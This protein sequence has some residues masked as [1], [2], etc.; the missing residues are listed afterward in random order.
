MDQQHPP[1]D[2]QHQNKDFFSLFEVSGDNI[3]RGNENH[4]Q[5][6]YHSPMATTPQ[7]A[8]NGA[9]QL[10]PNLPI[11]FDF[12]NNIMGMQGQQQSTSTQPP[13]QFNPQ[14]VIEQKLKLNQLQQ[15]QLQNQ[16]LQQQASQ[17]VL[18]LELLSG[19]GGMP[20]MEG[21][22]ERQ[23][24][25]SNYLGLPTPMSSTELQ[26]QQSSSNEYVSPMALNYID[27]QF[28]QEPQSQLPPPD[29]MAHHHM[30]HAAH[31]THSA[32]ANL[33]FNTNPPVPLPSP[34]QDM[35]FDLSPITSPWIEAYHPHERARHNAIT[36]A[37]RRPPR[38]S[39]RGP[40][41][42][43]LLPRSALRSPRR[44]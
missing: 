40:H 44:R 13:A 7:P 27:N 34:G 24:G 28:R 42:R 22:A 9:N 1:Q 37:P 31:A 5:G 8:M 26:P 18:N 10:L 29:M 17:L 43:A 20:A 3:Q 4:Q 36:S 32:P 35:E 12:L 25:N 2:E 41:A 19:Q 33:V 30:P 14:A 21:G 16:I 39:T 11:N 6:M 23:K 38:R 15:L